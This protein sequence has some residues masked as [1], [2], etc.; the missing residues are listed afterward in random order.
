MADLTP[1]SYKGRTLEYAHTN[2]GTDGPAFFKSRKAEAQR[3]S[4]FL[5]GRRDWWRG[6]PV[7]RVGADQGEFRLIRDGKGDAAMGTMEG[8]SI[9]HAQTVF[10]Y[11]MAAATPPHVLVEFSRAVLWS[12]TH[13]PLTLPSVLAREA[14]VRWMYNPCQ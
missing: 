10:G 11:D 12:P 5:E 14:F 3:D 9:C 1:T 4:W 8:N 7:R 2:I 13:G 6:H